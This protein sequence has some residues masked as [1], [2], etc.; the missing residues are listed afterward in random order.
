MGNSNADNVKPGRQ[1]RKVFKP[2]SGNTE[3]SR[4]DFE[5]ARNDREAIEFVEKA[6]AEG[7]SLERQGKIHR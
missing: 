4:S 6:K 7:E 1:K 5:A 3:I 2:R